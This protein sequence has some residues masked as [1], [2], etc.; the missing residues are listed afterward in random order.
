MGLEWAFGICILTLSQ[1]NSGEQSGFG[2]TDL[3]Y[4]TTWLLQ[5]R[6][7]DLERL[8]QFHKE[9]KCV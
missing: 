4:L 3:V 2:T 9:R 1:G 6:K 7:R 8:T 5:L